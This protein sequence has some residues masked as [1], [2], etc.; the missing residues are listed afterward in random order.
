MSTSVSMPRLSDSMEEGTGLRWIKGIGDTVAVG[1]GVVKITP[2]KAPVTYEADAAG[3]L[4]EILVPE[5]ETVAL[6]VELARIGQP[7]ENGATA[8]A[9]TKPR[10]KASPV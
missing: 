1:D 4:L 8:T 6:G 10:V 5:G 2:D 7:G 3:T 9:A